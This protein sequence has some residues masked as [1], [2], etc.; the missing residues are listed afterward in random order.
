MS[1]YFGRAFLVGARTTL[2]S[3]IVVVSVL[4]CLSFLYD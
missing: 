1:I 2:V 4:C 3:K